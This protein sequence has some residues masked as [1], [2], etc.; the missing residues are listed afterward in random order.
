MKKRRVEPPFSAAQ[1]GRGLAQH[2]GCGV[3]LLVTEV[4]QATRFARQALGIDVEYEDEDFAILR[5]MQ[6]QWLVHADHSYDRHPLAE[7]VRIAPVRGA[8][9]ELRVYGLDPD[10]VEQRAR[11]AGFTVMASA[12][13]KPHGLREVCVLDADGYLWVP[14]VAA[15]AP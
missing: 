12:A 7:R 9:V 5:W 8:G 4:A 1:L 15:V 10:T 3:N 2:G 11:D 13:T 6:S 14:S